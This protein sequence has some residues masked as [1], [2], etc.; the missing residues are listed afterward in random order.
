MF[1]RLA[2]GFANVRAG[3][4]VLMLV[5]VLVQAVPAGGVVEFDFV[6]AFLHGPSRA[7]SASRSLQHALLMPQVH[8]WSPY[9]CG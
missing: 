6:S 8:T 4:R 2:M 3:T 1:G 5:L 7:K 9:R